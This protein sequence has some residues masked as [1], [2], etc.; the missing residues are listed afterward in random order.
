MQNFLLSPQSLELIHSDVSFQMN[1]QQFASHSSLRHI[2]DCWILI[3]ISLWMTESSQTPSN[4]AL[5]PE[6]YSSLL[7]EHLR[8]SQMYLTSFQVFFGGRFAD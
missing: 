6:L 2:S 5:T 4:A 8:H 3:F 1:W 7:I